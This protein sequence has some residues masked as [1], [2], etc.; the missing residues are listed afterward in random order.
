MSVSLGNLPLRCGL[1]KAGLTSSFDTSGANI[2]WARILV[3]SEQ[4]PTNWLALSGHFADD[5]FLAGPA[6]YVLRALRRFSS[7]LVEGTG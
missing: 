7:L 3:C 4:A 5:G 6:S 2:A 1:S